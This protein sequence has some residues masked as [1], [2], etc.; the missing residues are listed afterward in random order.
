MATET[1]PS[2]ASRTEAAARLRDLAHS[3]ATHDAT[4]D[5]LARVIDLAHELTA[6][7]D[8]T[9]VRD[10]LALMRQRFE[11]AGFDGPGMGLGFEDRAVG[12]AANPTSV[13]MVVEHGDGPG[14]I[15]RAGAG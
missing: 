3:F 4:D 8:A 12:G 14:E 9:P 10:R 13:D 2:A 6:A 5:V 1:T 11:G 7:V 15:G